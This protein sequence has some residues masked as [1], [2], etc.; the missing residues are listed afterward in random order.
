MLVSERAIDIQREETVATWA[1][2]TPLSLF[3]GKD[4]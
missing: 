4:T 3:L 1:F 2:G